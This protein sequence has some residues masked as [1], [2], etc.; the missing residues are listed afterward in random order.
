MSA[1]HH[2]PRGALA[3]CGAAVLLL[4][5]DAGAGGCRAR[6]GGVGAGGAAGGAGA[7]E[8]PD[9]P[10]DGG[11]AG[12][13]RVRVGI[14]FDMAGK[15]D[16]SFNAA[17]WA[18]G[19]RAARQLPIVLRGA[20]PGDPASIEPSLR[21]FAERGFEL[22]VGVGFAQAPIIEEVARDYPRL[23]F[24]VVDGVARGPNVASLVF[25]EQEGAY[26]V[27]MIAARVS[28]TGV[29]GFVGGM[30]IP[31]IR[32]FVVG[33]E[34]GARAA[35][36][37]VRVIPSFVGVGEAAWN[38]PVRAKE[39]A[40]AEVSKG[41]D[42][43]FAAAG[44]SGLGVFDAAEQYGVY[45]IGVDSNQNW[46]KPG[47]VLTSMVKRVDNALVEIIAERV[48]GRIRGGVHS[49]GLGDGGIGYAMDPYNRGLIPPAVLR[50]VEE[51]RRRI[52]SGDI[53][54]TDAMAPAT[55][56]PVPVAAAAPP[57]PPAPP[58]PP[59]PPTPPG[60]GVE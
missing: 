11:G 4:L 19:Q 6:G 48:R 8:A 22:I 25:R 29:L 12:A 55:P 2:L 18:G 60:G 57:A 42:V 21:A 38:D 17:A 46:I 49:Y 54:V 30:D 37:G 35:R 31:L 44:N 13:G 32:K 53:R 28:R 52:L 27:G 51:A 59:I 26:L 24:A 7:P 45:V 34:E 43:I 23:D 58:V 5:L 40:A 33:Y 16:R 41:A 50:E 39:L 10:E 47:R 15:D 1:T 36:A 3:F 56:A 14:V 9:A 20:E